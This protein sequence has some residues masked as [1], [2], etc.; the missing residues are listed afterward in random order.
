MSSLARALRN[1]VI[2]VQ[3]LERLC[4]WSENF[5]AWIDSDWHMRRRKGDC[6]WDK[7][8]HLR[9]SC[10]MCLPVKRSDSLQRRH[11]STSAPK[12]RVEMDFWRRTLSWSWKTDWEPGIKCRKENINQK[13]RHS[14]E[15]ALCARVERILKASGKV[16]TMLF[17]Y[18]AFLSF[19]GCIGCLPICSFGVSSVYDLAGLVS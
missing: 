9:S 1:A 4:D 12:P 3:P 5:G 17:H 13:Q 16:D 10:K 7:K 14:N 6:Q 11:Q 15:R 19:S 2:S 18:F 8:R